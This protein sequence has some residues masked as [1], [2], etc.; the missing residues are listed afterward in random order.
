MIGWFDIDD[1][2]IFKELVM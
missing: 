1:G 2:V